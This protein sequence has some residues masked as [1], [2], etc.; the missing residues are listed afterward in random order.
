M[1]LEVQ[2]YLTQGAVLAGQGKHK[3]ALNYYE[4]AERENPLEIDVYLAKG[5]ACANIN[6]LDEA[7]VQFE[8]ALKVNRTSGLAYF[9]LGSIALLQGDTAFGLENYNK[10]IANGYDDAQLYYSLGLLHEENGEVDMAIRNY[11]KAIMRD[12]L[13]P[14]IRIRKARL[15]LQGN[16]IPEALQVLDETILTNPD[17]FEG[18]HLKFTVLMQLK[19]YAKAEELLH[20]ALTLFPKDPGFAIDKVSLL[21]AQAKIE[22]ALAALTT[23]ENAAETDDAVRRRIQMERAQ[24]YA[25]QEDVKSAISAL[26]KAKALFD[27]EEI[28]DTEVVFLLANCHLGIAEY[29][30]VLAYARLLLEKEESGYYKETAR[31]FEPL[32]LKMLGRMDEALPLYQEAI[33]EFRRQSLATPGNLDSYLLRIMCLRDTEQFAKALELVDYVIELQSE[34]PEPRLLRVTILEALG[35]QDEAAEET[36]AVNALLPAELRGK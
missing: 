23:L 15:L 27:Q 12:A 14:D 29:D 19:Q 32:A 22:E 20:Q 10:A 33:S 30:K 34:R 35:R 6:K 31:Y 2:E 26:E 24:I 8:K 9:H 28:F 18:Y 3:E 11:S 13:R 25:A 5:I 1:N 7:K 4:R 16:N 17:V 36:I 21:I